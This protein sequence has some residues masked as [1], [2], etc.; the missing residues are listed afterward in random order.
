MENEGRAKTEADEQPHR[1]PGRHGRGAWLTL[2]AVAVVG[3]LGVGVWGAHEVRAAMPLAALAM[4]PRFGTG[5]HQG[6]LLENPALAKERAAFA[7]EW[8]LRSVSATA[9]Q[10]ES[11]KAVT[12]QTVDTLVPLAELHASHAR[13]LAEALSAPTV[14]RE[15]IERVRREELKLADTASKTLLDAL[16]SISETL[17]PD[18]RIELASL[19]RRAHELR[20]DH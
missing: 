4:R 7:I 2:A 17:T 3:T 5:M 19:A 1:V 18:Q 13:A 10:R 12:Q 14:D 8:L 20:A 9:E 11:A 15:A 16:A 6:R